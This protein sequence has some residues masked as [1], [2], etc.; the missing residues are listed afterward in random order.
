MDRVV[1][2]PVSPVRVAAP[3]LKA[4]RGRLLS[5]LLGDGGLALA[6]PFALP[7]LGLLVDLLLGDLNELLGE[8]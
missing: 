4:P 1:R 5:R 3:G 6:I 2:N 7:L 8:A